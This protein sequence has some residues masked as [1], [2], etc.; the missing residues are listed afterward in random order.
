M[1]FWYFLLPIFSAFISKIISRKTS[2]A[3]LFIS[4]QVEIISITLLLLL[5]IIHSQCL[6]STYESIS[7]LDLPKVSHLN[8]KHSYKMLLL[9]FFMYKETEALKKIKLF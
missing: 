6:L 5:T 8:F 3:E 2:G 7:T 1:I 9:F 4:Y